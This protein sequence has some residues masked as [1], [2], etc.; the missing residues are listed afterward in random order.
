MNRLLR[1]CLV[2]L[3]ALALGL[4]PST[5]RATF[6]ITPGNN[7]Q[8]DENVLLDLGQSG[9]TVV[10]T[11]NDTGFSVFFTSNTQTLVTQASG[12][13]RVDT[14]T[15]TVNDISSISLA[16][17]NSYT[18]L[19]FN[20]SNG[21]GNL[22]ITVNGIESDGSSAPQLQQVFAIGNGN[23]FFTITTLL[24]E[25]ITSV[26]LSAP[27]GF[28][29]LRQ[30]RIGGAGPDPQAVPEPSTLALA[31][32]GGLGLLGYLRRRKRA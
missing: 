17:G 3:A 14:S 8:P 4:A 31:G 15:G 29:D 9:A 20:P 28:A 32:F 19:I 11:T 18:S 27:G 21:S 5:G 6:V 24:G 2:P 12:Q 25:R 7:P 30:V 16:P 22:T 13:A 23:N 10:G 1:L 26:A